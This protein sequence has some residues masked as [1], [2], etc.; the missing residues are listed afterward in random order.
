[1]T[2]TGMV[3]LVHTGMSSRR[4]ASASGHAL[5]HIIKQACQLSRPVML[6]LLVAFFGDALADLLLPAKH[7]HH[8]QRALA[9]HVSHNKDKRGT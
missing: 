5:G 7:L 3:V 2:T 9:P 1:M 4:G 6:Q 8:A